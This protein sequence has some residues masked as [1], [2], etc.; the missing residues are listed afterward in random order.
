MKPW[1]IIPL[2][3]PSVWIALRERLRP[4]VEH[5]HLVLSSKG[6]AHAEEHLKPEPFLSYSVQ[7]H[8]LGLGEAVFSAEPLWRVAESLL[9]VWGTHASESTLQATVQAH[10]GGLT[11]PLVE[12]PRPPVQFLFQ[13][14]KLVQVLQRETEPQGLCDVGLVMLST[15]G[16]LAAWKDF[17]T[18]GDGEFLDFLPYISQHGTPTRRV[19]V[20][21][22]DEARSHAEEVAEG[23]RF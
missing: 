11:L 6:L 1:A 13:G 20:S 18:H 15:R 19:F 22:P 14:D 4:L 10:R 16:L 2:A 23:F 17:R 5:V 3:E 12:L 8:P 9:I 21:D 7:D